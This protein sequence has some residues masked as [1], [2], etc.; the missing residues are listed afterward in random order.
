[1]LTFT[2][3]YIPYN[4]ILISASDNFLIVRLACG[5]ACLTAAASTAPRT[6]SWRRPKETAGNVV[7]YMPHFLAHFSLLNPQRFLSGARWN[8]PDTSCPSRPITSSFSVLGTFFLSQS[9]RQWGVQ[10]CL[11]LRVL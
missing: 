8:K 6:R 5:P 3:A 7:F 9:L 1:M 2:E 11:F 4:M 10:E